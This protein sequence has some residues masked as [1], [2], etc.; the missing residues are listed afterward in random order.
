[1]ELVILESPFAGDVERN[2]DYAR[3]CMLAIFQ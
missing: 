1:M 2:V 3:K